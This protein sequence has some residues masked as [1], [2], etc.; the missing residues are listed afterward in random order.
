MQGHYVTRLRAEASKE[1]ADFEGRRDHMQ[2]SG[3]YDGMPRSA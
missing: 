1:I 3:A 2:A